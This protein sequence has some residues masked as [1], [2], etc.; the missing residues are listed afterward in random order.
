[1]NRGSLG[2]RAGTWWYLP[3]RNANAPKQKKCPLLLMEQTAGTEGTRIYRLREIDQPQG[4]VLTSRRKNLRLFGVM[5]MR[6]A[7]KT[8]SFVIFGLPETEERASP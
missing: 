4:A 7:V 1:M 6:Q 2:V 5:V 3:D 8:A